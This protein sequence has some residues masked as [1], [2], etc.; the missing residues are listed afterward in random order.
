MK[1]GIVLQTKNAEDVWNALRF[2][3]VSLGAG[4][5]V[6]MFLLGDGVEIEK[7]NDEKFDVGEKIDEYVKAKGEILTCGSCVKL[8]E[9]KE[10][11]VC[12]IS[13]MKDLLKLVEESDKVLIFG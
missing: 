13:T 8:R 11:K 12:S 1:I 2:G 10:S 9:Q 4:H 3:I 7:I 5:G 6:K